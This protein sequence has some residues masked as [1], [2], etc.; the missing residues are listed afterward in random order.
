MNSRDVAVRVKVDASTDQASSKLSKF[1]SIAKG[2]A[3]GTAALAAGAIA[4]TAKLYEIGDRADDSNSRIRNISASMDLFGSKAGQVSDRLIKLANA[5]AIANGVDQNTIKATQAKLLTFGELA[6]TADKVGGNFD[7]ATQAAIDLAAAGFGNAESNATQL[8]K[9]LN[10]PIKGLAALAKSGVTFT[11]SEKDRIKT[12][13]ESNRVTEAQGIV[14]AAIE[15]QVG[16]TAASMSGGLDRLK[17]RASQAAEAVG[18]K[19]V[20]VV[21]KAADYVANKIAPAVAEA[22][23]QFRQRFG[24]AIANA[25]RI[26]REDVVPALSRLYGWVLDKVVPAVKKVLT[27]A[28]DGARAAFNTV[29][30]AI[31]D[32]SENLRTL[33]G[34]LKTTAEF[35]LEKVVPLWGKYL[36]AAFE[37]AG[38]AIAKLIG[39][40]SSLV[41]FL[42]SAYDK[43]TAVVQAI[44][45]VIDLAGQAKG[46]VSDGLSNV[47]LIGGIFGRTIAGTSLA[48]QAAT[49]GPTTVV[50]Q[51]D[52]SGIL[53]ETYLGARLAQILSD[54]L[55]RTGGSI[56][57]GGA[58]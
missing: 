16:G 9:A 5:Q 12:L 25:G 47:P 20:P 27:P 31:S 46:A 21:D 37:T 11:A 49:T 32:N 2:A 55:T 41:G 58:A 6:K 19:L 17:I 23:G 50:I 18:L 57:L 53:D 24:P 51:V 8:G 29:R 39:F 7:R 42:Q 1:G 4:A 34:W 13:V 35:V 3:I 54:H 48:P 43:A 56:V 14:L 40:I 38:T 44:R 10:D 52:G 45:S 15:K 28:I 36:K 33:G 22:A 30:D 26:I